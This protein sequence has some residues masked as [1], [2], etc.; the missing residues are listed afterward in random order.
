MSETSKNVRIFATCDIG[1]ALDGLR[2]RGYQLEVHPSPEPPPKQLIIEKVRSGID[3]LIIE[4]GNSLAT[5]LPSV[6]ASLP[7]PE[8]FLRQLK[9]KAGRPAEY[10]SQAI[11]VARYTTEEFT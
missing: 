5:L 10:W 2:A 9:R 7:T 3:G 1:P 8:Q 11:R 4:E 6:W